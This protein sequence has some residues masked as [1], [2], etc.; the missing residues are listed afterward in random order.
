MDYALIF[1]IKTPK[2]KFFEYSSDLHSFVVNKARKTTENELIEIKNE[3]C[4]IKSILDKKLSVFEYCK[5]KIVISKVVYKKENE[6]I[7]K[8]N[9][10]LEKMWFR[11]RPRS[12]NC[13]LKLTRYNLMIE[14]K[15]C[16]YRGL[17]TIFYQKRLMKIK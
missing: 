2:N 6:I 17:N 7:T 5:L 15:N 4:E 13:L 16:L 14:E 1:K 12:L 10:K 8:H 3:A 11:Q 9:S